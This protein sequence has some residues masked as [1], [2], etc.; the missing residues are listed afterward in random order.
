[1]NKIL[2]NILEKYY[3]IFIVATLL[4][5]VPL[6]VKFSGLIN[7]FLLLLGMLLILKNEKNLKQFIL[8]NKS[9]ILF[10][11]L[12]T[13]SVILYKQNFIQNLKLIALAIL[14]LFVLM[15]IKKYDENYCETIKKIVNVVIIFSFIVSAISLLLYMF[16]I[17]FALSSYKIG[18]AGND[19][20]GIYIHPNTAGFVA[21]I[22]IIFSISN[23]MHQKK[24]KIFNIINIIMQLLII[25]LAHSNAPLML[26][27]I[28]I[29]L[30]SFNK[31]NR[32]SKNINIYSVT[33]PF[34]YLFSFYSFSNI[35]EF[36]ANGRFKLWYAGYLVIKNNL[37]FGVGPANTSSAGRY[38]ANITGYSAIDNGGFH[39]S[40][41][42]VMAGVGILGFSV[43]FYII[44]KKLKILREKSNKEFFMIAIAIMFYSMFESKLFFQASLLPTIFWMLLGLA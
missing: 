42:E 3:L 10:I 16:N 38:Y 41:I 5:T 43:I 44:I 36:L 8:L 4:Y 15:N 24:Y 9:N 6:F 39:N 12:T 2:T 22:S 33:L 30:L 19:L 32:K 23:I 11:V 26:I 31:F 21:G 35:I 34:N 29:I 28:Y 40:Y 25:I 27:I 20:T 14:Q 17:N 13:I 1:M 18:K 7:M 37:L